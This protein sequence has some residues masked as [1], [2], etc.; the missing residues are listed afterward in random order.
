MNTRRILIDSVRALLLAALCC[1]TAIAFGGTLDLEGQNKG[2]TNWY[3]GNLQNWAELD[4]I[5][6]HVRFDK[7]QGTQTISISF[8][9]RHGGGGGVPGF[10]DLLNFTSSSNVLFTIPPVLSAPPTASDWSYTFTVNVSDN[11]TG[12]TSY[13]VGPVTWEDAAVYDVLVTNVCGAAFS[14]T[15]G[16]AGTLIANTNVNIAPLQS[17]AAC[18]G[19]IVFFSTKAS[20]TGPFAIAWTKDGA[21]LAETNSVL[22]LDTIGPSTY[23][24]G[25]SQCGAVTNAARLTVKSATVANPLASALKNPGASCTFVTTATGSETLTYAWTKNGVVIAMGAVGRQRFAQDRKRS[26]EC[27]LPVLP[28]HSPALTTERETTL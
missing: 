25:S 3:S 27:T 20:G 11:Q 1:N 7:A 6:C 14:G 24:A 21:P 4:Y 16:V 8:P 2:G 18:P 19:T 23:D 26:G 28:R 9:R 10:Q 13:S 15:N 12:Y 22:S 5:P 17:Q